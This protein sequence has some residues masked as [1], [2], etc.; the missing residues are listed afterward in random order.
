MIEGESGLLSVYPADQRPR[1]EPSKR[2]VTFHNGAVAVTYSADKPDLLRGPNHDLAWAD[3][4]AAWRYADAWDQ[5]MF[6][7]RIGD[8]P[9]VVVT[10]TPRPIPLIRNLV[11]RTD[12][13]VRVVTGSTYDNMAN[14]SPDFITEMRRRYENSRLGRQELY[15][16][17]L[18][19]V[20]GAL[21]DRDQIDAARVTD[22]PSL[23]KIVVAVD[24]AV[25]S[26][27]DSNE[28]GIIVAGADTQGHGYVLDDRSL[29]ASPGDWAA[30]AIAAY[31]THRADSIVAEANQGGDMVRH[32]LATVDSRVPVR[33]VRASRG[34]RTRAEPVAALYEQGRC[35]HVGM[36]STL[37]D[38]LCSWV[39]D[40]SGSP[41]RLDALVWAFTDLLIDGARTPA[42]VVPAS[43]EQTSPWRI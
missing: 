25:T 36:L 40:V 41:D 24:P 43:L 13:S 31:H 38:Q 2:R 8:H 39:P 3:E 1:Y 19:D 30:A 26:S 29:K 11:K 17:I 15:A 5:L 10:T 34:K 42:P 27:E 28:T 18:D 14:L 35:H 9:R 6:G 22:I 23:R 7:L 12:G 33:L 21:W 4:L 16:E 20:D 37:E 32:L